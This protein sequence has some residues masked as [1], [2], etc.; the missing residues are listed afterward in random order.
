[1][2]DY[3]IMPIDLPQG[4]PSVN[5][6]MVRARVSVTNARINTLPKIGMTYAECPGH[7]R[8]AVQQGF[9]EYILINFN[10]GLYNENDGFW[11]CLFAK[12]KTVEEA[13]KP[14]AEYDD[15]EHYVWP[16]VITSLAWVP[17]DQ[18]PLVTQLPD[19]NDVGT[20]FATRL[21]ERMGIREEIAVTKRVKKRIYVSPFPFKAARLI[22][23]EPEPGN[24]N[25]SFNGSSG[26]IKALHD[27]LTVVA[28]GKSYQTVLSGGAG[29]SVAPAP[30]RIFPATNH[31]DWGVWRRNTQ[32]VLPSGLYLREETIYFPPDTEELPP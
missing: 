15:N 27:D 10:G 22:C 18:F 12:S 3:K 30:E 13:N 11:S 26:S 16:T 7:S 24:V 19:G 28:R 9:G 5:E 1:M 6:V 17:D 21:Y 31:I 32:R 25:W 14:I 2:E 20:V 4:M 8:G 23:N 29:S